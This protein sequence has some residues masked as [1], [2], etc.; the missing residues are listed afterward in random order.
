MPRIPTPLQHRSLLITGFDLVVGTQNVFKLP[1][2]KDG[3]I[4]HLVSISPCVLSSFYVVSSSP[5]T[6]LMALALVE[7]LSTLCLLSIRLNSRLAL[8]SHLLSN[9]LS[10]HLIYG[11]QNHLAAA[12]LATPQ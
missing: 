11:R 10:P 12:I 1:P 8:L 6:R 3:M 9:L 7:P 5:P 2:F 4:V